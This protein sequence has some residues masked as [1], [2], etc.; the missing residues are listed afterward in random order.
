MQ[1][2]ET[3]KIG[4]KHNLFVFDNFIVDITTFF[5]IIFKLQN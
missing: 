2:V 4:N 5:L 3:I 1:N